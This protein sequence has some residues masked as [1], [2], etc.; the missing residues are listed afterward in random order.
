MRQARDFGAIGFANN[1]SAQFT[2]G[3]CDVISARVRWQRLH[4]LA[5]VFREIEH[6]RILGFADD[7]A[8]GDRPTVVHG[9]II[10]QLPELLGIC[11]GCLL[12]SYRPNSE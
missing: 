9:H 3:R 1:G 2:N 4:L 12:G 8:I 7:R 5:G 6:F 10:D 11:R